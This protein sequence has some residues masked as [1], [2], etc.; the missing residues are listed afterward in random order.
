MHALVFGTSLARNAL[1]RSKA[2][3]WKPAARISLVK[4]ESTDGSSSTT[5]IVA[6]L[7]IA[8]KLDF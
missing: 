3:T 7:Q 8:G 1:G 6:P 2:F 5:R 4:A